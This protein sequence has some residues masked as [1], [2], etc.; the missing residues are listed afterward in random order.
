MSIVVEMR[1]CRICPCTDFG[2][3]PALTIQGAHE[4]RS[5]R[6]VTLNPRR[7]AAGV[8][9]RFK[10]FPSLIGFPSFTDW[11]TNSSGPSAFTT[12]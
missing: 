1:E 5:E 12:L 9:C 4:V 11:K 7:Q 3:A 2:S 8:M 10:T 6:H